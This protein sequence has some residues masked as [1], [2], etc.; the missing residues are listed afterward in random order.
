MRGMT[1]L[2]LDKGKEVELV[3]III[4]SILFRFYCVIILY[5]MPIANYN[6]IVPHVLKHVQH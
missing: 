3:I 1:P 2:V 4:R 5:F 6:L